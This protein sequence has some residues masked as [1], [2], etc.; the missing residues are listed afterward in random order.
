MLSSDVRVEKPKG[1]D[2]DT[3]FFLQECDPHTTACTAHIHNAIELLYINEGSYTVFLD[4]VRYEV[5]R[6]DLILF[7]SNAIHHVLTGDAAQNSYYVIKIPPSAFIELCK[8]DVGVSYSMRFALHRKEYKHLWKRTE[9]AANGMQEIL[10]RLVREYTERRYATDVATK[11]GIIGLLLAILRESTPTQPTVNDMAAT[12]IYG[13]MRYVQQHYAEDIDERQLSQQ[14]G[15]SYSYFSRSFKRITGMTFKSYLNR[16]RVSKAEQ[17]LFKG[18]SSVSEIASECG[19][20]NTSYFI[21]VYRSLT[22]KTPYQ[23]KRGAME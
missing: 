19:Y 13:V 6:G 8:Q 12:Q 10:D 4:N 11:L 2:R 9:L 20:N 17:L 15:M 21:S 18:G 5:E 16:T 3:E 1:L 22:G 7:C 14:H 23:A